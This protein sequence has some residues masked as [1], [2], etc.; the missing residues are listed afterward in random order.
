MTEL[1]KPD[2]CVIGA[3]SGG[4]SVAAAAAQLGVPVVLIEKAVMGGDC[5]N[6]GCVPSKSLIASARRAHEMR[7][8]KPLGITPTNP[9]INLR[10]VHEHVRGVIAAIAPNDS[11]ERFT[12]LG[13][14]VIQAPA[15]FVDRETVEAGD[16]Q[17]KA[18]RFVVAA[19]SSPALPPI[20]GIDTVS[21][22]TNETIFALAERPQHLVVVGGGPIGI[23]LA[24]AHLR[25]GCRVTVIEAMKAL[26]LGDPELTAPLIA[27]LREEGLTLVEGAKVERFERTEGGINVHM[28]HGGRSETVAAS[29]VLMATGRRA[30]V[31]N[32]G[33]DQ[34]GIRY[35]KS[36][37]R[38]S[39]GLRTSNRR[40]YAIGDVTGGPQFTH[41]AS[42][43]AGIVIRS[44]LFR[45]PA[46]VN[47]DIMP[48]VTFTDPELAHV[49]LSEDEARKRHG[50]RISVVRWPYHE[51]DRAQTERRTHGF[52]KVVTTPSGRILGAS[53]LGAHAGEL[54]QMW[55]LAITA[56]LSMKHMASVIAPYPTFSEIN[57]RAAYAYYLPRLANPM[58]RSLV[59]LLRKLG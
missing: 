29:H 40:V 15:R 3:G 44:A 8:A 13:V 6:H 11:V 25:L 7:S 19:G 58:V 16:Y 45:L 30:N 46:R 49:G 18:R 4:L 52:V 57:K 47:P 12:G 41:A 17:V 56:G 24:Q 33:L 2:L 10:F 39:R 55:A 20:P 36:G 23:E 42:Y 26:G 53:I 43:Q 5:L 1:L 37:I 50:R 34:A 27:E 31:D 9:M 14:R 54:I 22:L 32:L 38:V 59:S 35:D 51:N 28:S 21:V 48:W